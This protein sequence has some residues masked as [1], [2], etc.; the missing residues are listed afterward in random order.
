MNLFKE[1]VITAPVSNRLQFGFN[2]NVIISKIDT[3]VRKVKGLP[4]KANTFIT[5]SQIN[6]ETRKVVAQNEFNFW[7]LDSTTDFVVGNF[8]EQWT[9]LLSIVDALGKDIVAYETA[10]FSAI[11]DNDIEVYAKT[12]DGA[13]VLQ[14]ALQDSFYELVKDSIGDACPLLKCKLVVNKKGYLEIS[15]VSGWVLAMTDAKALPEMTATEKRIRAEALA[16]TP[17]K[18]VNPDAPGAPK[19]VTGEKPVAAAG[20]KGL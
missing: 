4:I 5:L 13:K 16:A 10:V 20:F 15:K 6:P 7:N 19:P 12:K 9:A 18:K 1:L 2:E 3:T 11:G 8:L 17:E 14:D